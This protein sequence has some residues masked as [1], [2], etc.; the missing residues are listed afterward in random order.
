MWNSEGNKVDFRVNLIETII[1]LQCTITKY[2]Q[3]WESIV[4]R[5]IKIWHDKAQDMSRVYM[6]CKF[7]IILKGYTKDSLSKWE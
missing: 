1:M 2:E 4:Y 6:E 5:P 7:S 3:K